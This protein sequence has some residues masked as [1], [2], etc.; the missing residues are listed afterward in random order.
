MNLDLDLE[1]EAGDLNLQKQSN[2][3]IKKEERQI[4]PKVEVKSKA[5]KPKFTLGNLIPFDQL[6]E[7]ESSEN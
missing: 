4:L 7:Q 2:E 1:S 6:L 3:V 5:N